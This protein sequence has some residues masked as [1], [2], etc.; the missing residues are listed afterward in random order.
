MTAEERAIFDNIIKEE[1]TTFSASVKILLRQKIKELKLELTGELR[2][3]IRTEIEKQ[4]AEEGY[5]LILLFRQYGRFKDMRELASGNMPPVEDME[6]YVKKVGVDNFFFIPGYETSR[7]PVTEQNAIR[8]IAWGLAMSKKKDRKH[9][10]MRWFSRPFYKK[11]RGVVDAVVTR[12]AKQTKTTITKS[13]KTNI[14][15]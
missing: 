15:D 6:K 2:D 4:S 8:R 3:S 1:L 10:A 13:F 5:K 9:T 7:K 14:Q 11:I 12:Y